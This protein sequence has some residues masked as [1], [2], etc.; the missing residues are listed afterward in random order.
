MAITRK[1]RNA[2]E[3]PANQLGRWLARHCY[4]CGAVLVELERAWLTRNAQWA[5][6]ADLETLEYWQARLH[7]PT[8][9]DV[10]EEVARGLLDGYPAY[11]TIQGSFPGT[12][13]A[14]DRSVT[15]RICAPC[16]VVV[17]ER[18]DQAV[19]AA[20][21]ATADAGSAAGTPAHPRTWY[22]PN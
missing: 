20:A 19:A 18:H 11:Y 15:Y 12:Q 21:A 22:R 4:H 13:D 3:V 2:D 14:D 6:E 17:E 7:L 8:L 5:E 1:Y 9:D 10:R 16:L